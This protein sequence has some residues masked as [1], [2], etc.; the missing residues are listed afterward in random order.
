MQVLRLTFR[1]NRFEIVAVG[2]LGALIVV[3]GVLVMWRLGAVGI[4]STCLPSL[5]TGELASGCDALYRE[6]QEIAGRY[7]QLVLLIGAFLPIVGGLLIGGPPISREIERGTAR[8]AWSLSPSRLRWYAHRVLPMIAFL[9]VVAF[10]VG[11]VLDRLLG[12]INVGEDLSASFTSF[13]MRGILV[14]TQA[15]VIAASG[16]ALGAIL[17]RSVPTFLL[18]LILSTLLIYG[19]VANVHRNILLG[20]ADRQVCCETYEPGQ[21]YLDTRIQLPDGRLVSYEELP[22]LDAEIGQLAFE[23]QL[24][25]V[26]LVIPGSR[27]R[28]LETREAVAHTAIVVVL[29]VLAAVVVDRRR[30]A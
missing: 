9:V 13:R 17:G 1:M 7:G 5:E 21:L 30:P 25:Q 23:G 24:P 26:S 14:A 11:V 3:G 22:S 10:A 8:L 29:L 16:I 28:E 12:A 15:A 4:S 20:E 2:A 6:F 27:Y 18:S 19:G